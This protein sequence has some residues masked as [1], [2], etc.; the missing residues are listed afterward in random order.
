[1]KGYNV[2]GSDWA[3]GLMVEEL[4]DS[5]VGQRIFLFSKMPRLA[6]GPNP[7]SCSVG[8]RVYFPGVKSIQGMKLTNQCLSSAK[9]KGEWRFTSAPDTCLHGI[10]K[11]NF[12][13]TWK[14]KWQRW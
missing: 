2:V 10:H 5:G 8:A 12:T 9:V 11:I 7:A 13:F 3:A 14:I 1:M 4:C 6:L